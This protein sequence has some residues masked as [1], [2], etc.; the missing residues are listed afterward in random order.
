MFFIKPMVGLAIKIVAVAL[1]G[2]LLGCSNPLAQSPTV[3]INDQAIPLDPSLYGQL[4]EKLEFTL[5]G[6]YPTVAANRMFTVTVTNSEAF[7]PLLYPPDGVNQ[8]P[9]DPTVWKGS[10]RHNFLSP[11]AFTWIDE[12]IYQPRNGNFNNPVMLPAKRIGDEK[13]AID[14]KKS[15][16]L[17]VLTSEEWPTLSWTEPECTFD[18]Q[19]ELYNFRDGL[20]AGIWVI[21]AYIPIIVI[22]E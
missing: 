5:P 7:D 12:K 22:A 2:A 3:L 6:G 17:K 18:R 14:V 1:S 21:R 10:P 19:T 20:P 16:N 13:V 4:S 9:T 8:S 11:A 15:A